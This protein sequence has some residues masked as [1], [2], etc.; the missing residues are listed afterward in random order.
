MNTPTPRQHIVRSAAYW[1][2]GASDPDAS[3]GERMMALRSAYDHVENALAAERQQ[4]AAL[5][6][7]LLNLLNERIDCRAQATVALDGLR[8]HRE[9][10]P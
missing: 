1:Y 3:P 7:A 2:E 8:K 6:D 10:N 5:A 4:T 9:I